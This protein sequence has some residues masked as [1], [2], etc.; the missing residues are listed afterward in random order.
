MMK[1]SITHTHARAN[2]SFCTFRNKH[3]V[4]AVERTCCGVDFRIGM[5][6][7]FSPRRVILR[8]DPELLSTAWLPPPF[9]GCARQAD[10]VASARSSASPPPALLPRDK[11]VGLAAPPPLARSPEDSQAERSE[12]SF[13]CAENVL[14]SLGVELGDPGDSTNTS[15]QRLQVRNPNLCRGVYLGE[16]EPAVR[17][18][19]S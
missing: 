18:G 13:E 1:R 11:I 15:R 10:D 4:E 12:D 8:C 5:L 3:L 19:L 6:P 16:L 17:C 14:E 9:P 2:A 7:H